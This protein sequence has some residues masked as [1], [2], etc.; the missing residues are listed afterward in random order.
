MT[1]NLVWLKI[2]Y[3]SLYLSLWFSNYIL[4]LITVIKTLSF[5]HLLK[6]FSFH[7]IMNFHLP[8]LGG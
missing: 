3:W 7:Y 4:K 1:S 5:Q 8:K 2:H 6:G